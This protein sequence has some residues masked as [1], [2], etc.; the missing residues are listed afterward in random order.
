MTVIDEWVIAT[1][2]DTF[3]A[4]SPAF[5][6]DGSIAVNLTVETLLSPSFVVFLN[7]LMRSKGFN[8]KNLILEIVET[9]LMLDLAAAKR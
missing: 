6:E 7:T 3:S 8:P 4:L 5:K 2:I 9:S 1:S